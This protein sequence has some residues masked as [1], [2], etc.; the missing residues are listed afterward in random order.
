VLSTRKY[1][2][3]GGRPHLHTMRSS[4]LVTGYSTNAEP[5][6][7]HVLRRYGAFQRQTSLGFR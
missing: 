4:Y 2:P 6:E 3:P 7:L 1:W 5:V